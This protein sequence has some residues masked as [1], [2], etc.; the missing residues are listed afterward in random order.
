MTGDKRIGDWESGY[1][2]EAVAAFLHVLDRGTD[3]AGMESSQQE[4]TLAGAPELPGPSPGISHLYCP[5]SLPFSP[6]A[7]LTS[8]Y[9]APAL[10]CWG[11]RLSRPRWF[12]S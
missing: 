11:F 12:A 3:F 9:L 2:N 7:L 10:L 8:E 5:L 6:A 1:S 4:Q